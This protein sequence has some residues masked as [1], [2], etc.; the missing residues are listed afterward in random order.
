M[1]VE[2][3]YMSKPAM[4]SPFICLVLMLPPFI[5]VSYAPLT[6]IILPAAVPSTAKPPVLMLPVVVIFDV[7]PLA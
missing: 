6:V 2:I 5:I 1:A 7:T 3:P 4:S